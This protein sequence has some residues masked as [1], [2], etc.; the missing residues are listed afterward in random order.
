MPSFARR[1]AARMSGPARLALLACAL[2]ALMSLSACD[3]AKPPVEPGGPPAASGAPAPGSNGQQGATT[4]SGGQQTVAVQGQTE[5]LNTS[6]WVLPPPFYAAG[7][8]PFWRLEINDGWFEFRRSG[9]TAI[10]EPLVQPKQENGAD[11]FATGALKVSIKHEACE[12]DQGDKSDYVAKVTFDGLDFDG[13]A[14]GGQ[15]A[16]SPEASIVTDGLASI[17]ACLAK[18]AQPA[19]VTAVYPRQDGEQKA[20]ALRA[21]S[22]QLYECATDAAGATVAY[23][24]PIERG[25]E[26]TWMS[27]MRFLRSTVT[28][29]ATCEK[30]EEVRTGDQVIG[31]LL[32]KGCKF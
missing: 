22:G 26:E 12:T 21:R 1:N 9:L 5:P 14:S 8:E 13:C 32:A 28:T 4:T 6:T 31:K 7:Q 25:A 15:V 16:A 19:V 10:E 18:L 20:V 24:D 23:L 27:R 30:A 29:T 2:G 17:D 3:G 11:V